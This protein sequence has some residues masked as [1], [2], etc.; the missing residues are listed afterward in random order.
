M[1]LQSLADQLLLVAA[2]LPLLCVC[3]CALLL[4][5]RHA[6]QAFTASSP[7]LMA[8]IL[9]GVFVGAA[10]NLLSLLPPTVE[11]CGVEAVLATVAFDLVYG[12]I[13]LKNHRLATIFANRDL[14]H[15]VSISNVQLILTLVVIVAADVAGTWASLSIWALPD[16]KL[17]TVADQERFFCSYSGDKILLLVL[18]FSAMKLLLLLAA[19][20]VACRT[21][22]LPR[23]FSEYKAMAVVVALALIAVAQCITAISSANVSTRFITLRLAFSLWMI[24][25]L[26][27]MFLPKTCANGSA[28]DQSALASSNLGSSMAASSFQSSSMQSVSETAATAA[29][30]LPPFARTRCIRRLSAVVSKSCVC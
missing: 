14:L 9:I 27:A 20:V 17:E 7:A 23:T 19:S 21:R 15:V 4:C 12:A 10:G 8:A 16:M 5:L 13:W 22:S 6:N 28:S 29:V 11:Y 25:V 1:P 24:G 30:L 18:A 2:L 3:I 26:V